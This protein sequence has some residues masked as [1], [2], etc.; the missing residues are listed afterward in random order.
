MANDRGININ[1]PPHSDKIDANELHP[2]NDSMAL[3]IIQP[4]ELT[5]VLSKDLAATPPKE[6]VPIPKPQAFY[7]RTVPCLTLTLPPPRFTV[8]GK[9]GEPKVLTFRVPKELNLLPPRPDEMLTGLKTNKFGDVTY[10]KYKKTTPRV[11]LDGVRA[12]PE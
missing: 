1:E 2:S 10:M 9:P 3:T 4:K 5:A 7:D 12:M 6:I 8:E 11:T